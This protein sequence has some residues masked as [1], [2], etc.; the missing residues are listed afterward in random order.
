MRRRRPSNWCLQCRLQRYRDF[1]LARTLVRA[2]RSIFAANADAIIRA[3]RG[4]QRLS[5][6]E[7]GAGTAEKTGILLDAAIRAQGEVIYQP[8]DVS[9]SALDEAVGTLSESLPG[10]RV[11][12]LVADY[13]EGYQNLPRPSGRRLALYIGSSIGNFEPDAAKNVLQQ[14]R[15]EL[16]AGDHLLLGTDLRKE[17]ATL[18][19]AY[20]DAA[21][22]TAAFNK[23]VLARINAELGA[24]FDLDRFTH[25]ARWNREASRMEMHL[26]SR[27]GQRVSIP[28]L[29]L[30][31]DFAN[32]ESIHTENS[33]KFSRKSV[34]SL[35][36]SGGFRAA[37]QW[38]DP[39]G[40]FL[41]TLA[42]AAL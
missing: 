37:Q 18:L 27:G 7:L 34:A 26:V 9:A 11:Q 39:E 6:V 25:Q 35:L 16:R 33:Y 4:G 22:V 13:T 30:D 23:N 5:I 19:A 2:E 20:D 31:V 41:V 24:D 42:A 40:R 3:A 8:V 28:A 29:K 1:R 38:T 32:G 36:N 10:A 17:E 21:G 15:G 12:P 14:L